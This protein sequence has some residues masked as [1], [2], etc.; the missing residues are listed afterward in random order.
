M[1]DGPYVLATISDDESSVVVDGQMVVDNA[2]RRTW[3]RGATGMVTL[4]RGVHAIYVRYARDE[5][6]FHFELL[7][8][9]AGQPLERMPAWAL[10]PRRVGF[11]AF[12]LSAG[13]KRTL[14]AAQWLWVG[15]DRGRGRWRWRGR[16]S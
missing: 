1:H 9:R 12:A 15:V 14:A 7:W 2:G 5:G 8:A 3:P 13:L 16:G 10:T 6:P 4:T 11:W